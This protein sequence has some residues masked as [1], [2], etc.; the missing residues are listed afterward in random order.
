[1]RRRKA[2]D[3]TRSISGEPLPHSRHLPTFSNS[4]VERAAPSTEF[5]KQVGPPEMET[6]PLY[7]IPNGMWVHIASKLQPEQPLPAGNDP[8]DLA[9][10]AADPWPFL[11]ELP[12][13]SWTQRTPSG[14][15]E[16]VA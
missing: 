9:L 1:M 11:T 5:S 7:R 16:H 6:H 13:Q 4:L 10:D 15:E 8:A 14:F 2:S 3:P 12:K